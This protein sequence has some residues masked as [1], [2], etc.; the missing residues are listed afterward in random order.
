M[1][2]NDFTVGVERLVNPIDVGTLHLVQNFTGALPKSVQEK[3][4]RKSAK[5]N[6]H[7]GFVVEPY[8]YFLSYEI[9]DLEWAQSLLPDGFKMAK[10]NVVQDDTPKYYG[11]FGIFNAHTSGFWG[12]RVEFYIIAEDT[13]TGLLSWIIID[14]DTNTISYDP[15]NGLSSPNSEGSTFTIDY[16]GIIH[17]D[18]NRSDQSHGLVLTSDIKNGVIKKL[19]KRL[20][21]EGNLS[22]GYGKIMSENDASVFSLKFDPKE[23]DQALEIDMN[24]VDIE[25]NNWFPGL[26]EE[27]P[28]VVLC[29][30]Y[31]QHFLSDSPGYYSQLKTEE[32]LVEEVRKVDFKKIEIF[33]TKS[34]RKSFLM[35]TVASML[36]NITLLIL[37]IA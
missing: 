31:A 26:F 28:S 3:M 11:I 25:L 37:L 5:K 10:T 22:I 7:M 4:I 9:K 14:Y 18:V 29:F 33:S 36:I 20:W 21:I 34:L 13:R 16:D 35:G 32:E 2:K 12:L 8:S 6:P 15:K 1:K 23:F 19:D 27:K 17:V 30:P 24:D